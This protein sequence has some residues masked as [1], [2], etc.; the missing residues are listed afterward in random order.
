MV[1]TV[2]SGPGS[3]GPQFKAIGGNIMAHATTTRLWVKKSGKENRS[4]AIVASPC[5]PESDAKF[6]LDD[7]GVVDID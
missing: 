1:A 7:C 6:K 3:F 5:L 4:V 2:E